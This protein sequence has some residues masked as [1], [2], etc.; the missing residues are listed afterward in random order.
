M[1]KLVSLFAS[2]LFIFIFSATSFA[3]YLTGVSVNYDSRYFPEFAYDRGGPEGHSGAYIQVVAGVDGY[4]DL[5]NINIKAKHLVND[6]EVTL[7]EA[8]TGCAGNWPAF[9]G[10]DQYYAVRL[11]PESKRMVG[12]WVIT[13]KYT[14]N[15]GDKGQESKTVTVPRFNFPPEPTGIQRSHYQGR[16]WLVWNSIG[17]PGT[18]PF[19]HVE[20][21]IMRLTK[22]LFCVDDAYA[23]RPYGNIYY[24]LWSGNRIAVEIPSGWYPGDLIRIENRVYDDNGGA[25]YRF[26]RGVRFIYLQ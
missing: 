20:Y 9:F 25:V 8:P 21:R 26:D 24:E 5:K 2:A 17:D 10:V 4:D 6:F 16:E 1:K 19:K 23:V 11:Q 15:A 12:Q 13:L 7:L 14:T 18:G 22:P 3:G